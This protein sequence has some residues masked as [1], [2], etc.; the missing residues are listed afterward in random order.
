MFQFS[1]RF[2]STF[3]LLNQTPLYRF[4]VGLFLRHSLHVNVCVL[5]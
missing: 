3:R 2:F 5:G 1:S 4:K